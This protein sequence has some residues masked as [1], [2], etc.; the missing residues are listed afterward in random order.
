VFIPN[1]RL[2]SNA[3]TKVSRASEA[4]LIPK[5]SLILE[6]PFAVGYG[7]VNIPFAVGYGSVNI[8]VCTVFRVFIS[9]FLTTLNKKKKNMKAVFP[10]FNFLSVSS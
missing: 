9:R 3:S 6:L 7:S 8:V 1:G 4:E 5:C 10:K 2:E